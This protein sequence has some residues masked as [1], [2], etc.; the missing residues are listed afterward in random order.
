MKLSWRAR[1]ALFAGHGARLA[2]RWFGRGGGT[3]LPGLVAGTLAPRLIEEL[4]SD[5]RYD[6][7]TITGTNG[8]T[9]TTHLL[10][11]I[12]REAGF[13]PLTNYAGSNL[14]RGLLTAYLSDVTDQND[15]GQDQAKF[16]VFE[17]DE[18]NLPSL[19][20]RLQPRLVTFLNLFRDQLDRYGEV[21]SVMDGWLEMLAAAPPRTHLVLNVDDPVIARFDEFNSSGTGLVECDKQSVTT[22]G[23]DDRSVELQLREHARDARF[24]PK[25]KRYEY[26]AIFMGH[27]GIWHCDCCESRRPSPDVSA[28][29]VVLENS[30]S[31]VTFSIADHQVDFELPLPGLYM[32][33]NALAAAA[34]A[35]ALGVTPDVIVRGLTKAEAPFGRQ[36]Q[37]ILEEKTVRVLLAKNPAGLNEVIRILTSVDGPLTVLAM[38]NDG[39]QD[40]QDVSWIYDAEIELLADYKPT[41]IVSGDRAE[42]MALRFSIAG[43]DSNMIE[44]NA[45]EALGIA[46]EN[47]NPGEQLDVVATYT[48]MIEIRE[49]L[50]RRAG[51]ASYWERPQWDSAV[52]GKL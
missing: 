52:R 17:V 44:P 31:L 25:G 48:A 38:L 4:A 28:R 45:E 49:L 24:C 11:T 12:I 19:L 27:V 33:Y 8:K 50:A 23:V 41:L 16:A 37:F 21:D 35:H 42:D 18:A 3:A 13:D 30:R 7:V 15:L 2:T 32:V 46:L 34:S 5:R 36:E 9:T 26:D 14:E 29:R 6:T 47:V 1:V 22:Y 51:V 40:G 39:V 20:P 43:I 10:A